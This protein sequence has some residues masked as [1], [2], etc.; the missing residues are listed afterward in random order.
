MNREAQILLVEDN[1]MDVA[2]TINA[3]KEA[4]LS[5]EIHVVG[6][7]EEALG[8]IKGEGAY[9]D[10]MIHPLPDII[11][12]D[13]KMPGLGGFEFLKIIKSSPLL[14]RIPVIILTTSRNEEDI[15]R[16]YDYGANSYLV[17]PINFDGFQ[18]VVAEVSDYWFTLNVSANLN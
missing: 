10:R 16:S 7:S 17:K 2:L 13:L 4:H 9:S 15:A 12:L 18:K 5:N 14:K 8:Y 6:S 3:F 1:P 11:L